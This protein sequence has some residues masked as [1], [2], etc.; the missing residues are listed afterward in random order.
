MRIGLEEIKEIM[1]LIDSSQF[2]EVALEVD[3]ISLNIKKS[4]GGAVRTV[5]APQPVVKRESIEAEKEDTKNVG[6]HVIEIL[7][8]MV[9]TFYCAPSPDAKPYV[10]VGDLVEESTVVCIVEAM[11]LM[12]EIQAEHNGRIVEVL[13]ENGELVEFGKPLFLLEKV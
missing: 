9:G 3:G 12:N 13:V 2:D 4:R 1:K 7:S 5:Q 11:K 6:K 10:S 8:P